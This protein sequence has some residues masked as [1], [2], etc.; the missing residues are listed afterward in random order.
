MKINNLDLNLN[1]LNRIVL[2]NLI[3][4]LNRIVTRYGRGSGSGSPVAPS[5]TWPG[6]LDQNLEQIS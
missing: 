4:L 1:L 2:L 5:L 3:V 6:I